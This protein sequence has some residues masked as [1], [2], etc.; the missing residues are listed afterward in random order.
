MKGRGDRKALCGGQDTL[1][2]LSVLTGEHDT[3]A[4]PWA[5]IRTITF[6]VIPHYSAV[7]KYLSC[8]L[9]NVSMKW[10][11]GRH[12]ISFFL[13][14]RLGRVLI[15]WWDT[16][17]WTRHINQTFSGYNW[18]F[19]LG[20]NWIVFNPITSWFTGVLVT[21]RTLQYKMATDTIKESFRRKKLFREINSRHKTFLLLK[22]SLSWSN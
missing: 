1:K 3:V 21:C 14:F 16:M 10:T 12:F 2:T 18:N 15:S 20:K 22:E 19:Y 6:P 8:Q 11:C 9:E 4:W 5:E 7:K 17:A 13:L